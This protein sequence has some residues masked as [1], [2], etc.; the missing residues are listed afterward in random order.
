MENYV[1]VNYDVNDVNAENLPAVETGANLKKVALVTG[2]V[3]AGV[4]TVVGVKALWKKV[5]KPRIEARRARKAA[6]QEA[7]EVEDYIEE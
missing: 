3:A 7:V 2:I 5:I 4:A 6:E 1:D